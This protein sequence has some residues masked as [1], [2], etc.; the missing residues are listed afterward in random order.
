MLGRIKVIHPRKSTRLTRLWRR[1]FLRFLS[2]KALFQL[3]Q[4][5]FERRTPS[6]KA[7]R[8]RRAPRAKRLVCSSDRRSGIAPAPLFRRA[9][10]LKLRARQRNTERGIR[11]GDQAK[12]RRWRENEIPCGEPIA[13]QKPHS[14]KHRTEDHARAFLEETPNGVSFIARAAQRGTK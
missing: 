7:P 6:S 10:G 5:S 1:F 2:V 4:F 11:G 8:E 13:L 3:G 12:V 9:T 14:T